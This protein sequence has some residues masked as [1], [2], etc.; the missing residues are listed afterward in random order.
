MSNLDLKVKIG[1]VSHIMVVEK[2]LLGKDLQHL[3]D[4]IT[5]NG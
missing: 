5:N 2:N 3:L 1:L 4:I